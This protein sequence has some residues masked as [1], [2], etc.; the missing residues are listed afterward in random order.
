MFKGQ[1]S[2]RKGN[3]AV[4]DFEEI[5][6]AMITSNQNLQDSW[7]EPD[8]ERQRESHVSQKKQPKQ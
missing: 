3:R 4:K 6:Q 5:F 1:W 2:H 7:N 8:K